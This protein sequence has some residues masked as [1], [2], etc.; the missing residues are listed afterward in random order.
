[1]ICLTILYFHE[2]R[3]LMLVENL[4]VT[5][6]MSLRIANLSCYRNPE[7]RLQVKYL[8]EGS[9]KKNIYFP[10]TPSIIDFSEKPF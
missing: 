2:L 5:N 3:S 4:P 9:T 8:R 10:K 1:M 7:V 6:Y